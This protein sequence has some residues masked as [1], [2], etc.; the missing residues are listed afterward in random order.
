MLLS[1]KIAKLQ[2]RPELRSQAKKLVENPQNQH[3]EDDVV[4]NYEEK[5]KVRRYRFRQ[6]P[7]HSKFAC[8]QPVHAIH[9]DWPVMVRNNELV[10]ELSLF[11]E[12]K[13]FQNITVQEGF[14]QKLVIIKPNVRKDKE[15]NSMLEIMELFSENEDNEQASWT[16]TFK[17]YYQ[18]Y[19]K[20]MKRQ[21]RKRTKSDTR[22]KFYTKV[23]ANTESKTKFLFENGPVLQLKFRL[24]NHHSQLYEIV[25]GEDFVKELGHTT[26]SFVSLVLQ[27][28]LPQIMPF[29]N[30]ASTFMMKT[31]VDNYFTVDEEGCEM[32]G[33]NSTLLMKNGYVKDIQY[34]VNFLMNYETN[35][36]GM[37]VLYSI[38]AKGE[39]Y[40]K[41]PVNEEKHVNENFVQNMIKIE[42]ET[43][44][45]LSEYY[46]SHVEKRYCYLDKIC[47]VK[48]LEV[49]LK[50]EEQDDFCVKEKH[51]DF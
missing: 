35:S 42:D 17:N 18:T 4:N 25:F 14:D 46:E 39:P 28:G 33:L 31:L 45:F 34:Q 38:T 24:R 47:R 12:Y 50:R 40:L 6:I 22:K 36:F 5:G 44:Q 3:D 43:E 19:D 27:E 32:R 37:D 26:D 8:N 16:K 7:P 10:T 23:D 21:T 48:E 51:E 11:N 13:M 1:K 20:V 49:K 2:K 41:Y 9:G 29:D 15:I 30:P